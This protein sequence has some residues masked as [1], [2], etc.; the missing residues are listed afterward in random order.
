[1]DKTEAVELIENEFPKLGLRHYRNLYD[2]TQKIADILTAISRAKDEVVDAAEYA[3]LAK[4][5]QSS[6]PAARAEEA[7]KALEVAEVYRCYE[8]LKQASQCVDFGDLVSL[9]VHLLEKNAAVREHLRREYDHVLVDEYQD[10]NR[11]SVLLLKALCG[12]GENLWVV[13]DAKQSIY[14][15]RGASSFNMRRFGREDFP[16]GTKGRL[17]KNYR[18]TP[19][20][21]DRFSLFAAQMIAGGT[22]SALDCTRDSVGSEPEFRTVITSDRRHLH[23]QPRHST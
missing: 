4:A 8:G 22:G 10:V 17:K 3:R 11:S 2:P 5:M 1:M 13:G 15:F 16:G 21:V 7:E 20:I 19:E 23:A 9:P 12:N 6:V 14:R 18:S